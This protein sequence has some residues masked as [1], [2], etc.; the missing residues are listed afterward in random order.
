MP[1]KIAQIGTDGHQNMVLD[2]I[3]HIPGAQLIACAKGHPDDTLAKVKA[4]TAFTA[5]TRLYDD[6]RH[7]LDT[8]E[9]DLVS[10]CRPYSLNAEA[11][12][13]AANRGIDIVS[14]KPVA[15]TLKDLDA[16][17]TAVKNSGIRLTAMF[18][19]RLSPAFRAAHQA[20]QDGLIGE[21]ILANRAKILSLWHA[22]GLFQTS[23]KLTAAQSPGSQSTPSITRAGQPGVNTHKSPHFTATSPIPTIPAAKTT[24]VC[25]SA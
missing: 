25:S 24:A 6:Y 19:L 20:V 17:E 9:I 14:E 2:G 13:D 7:M 3:A 11:S 12:I 10:I 1:L 18:G 15:T 4:H 16:L 5:H 23:E 22:P 21:P 8:E